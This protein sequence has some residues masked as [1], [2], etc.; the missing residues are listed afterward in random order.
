MTTDRQDP[1][2]DT[3]A[4]GLAR[5]AALF[6]TF[7]GPRETAPPLYKRLR[8]LVQ[9]APEEAIT[10][11]SCLRASTTRPLRTTRRSSGLPST[12]PKKNT[13]PPPGRARA[14]N[15]K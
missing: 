8:S 6:V 9:K 12:L 15:C 13:L 3:K 1:A 14:E 2:T 4:E 7:Y 10:P 5:E 11:A